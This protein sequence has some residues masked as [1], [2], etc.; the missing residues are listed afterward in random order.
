M[1]LWRR[2]PAGSGRWT[3]RAIPEAGLALA[4]D[5]A[6]GLRVDG[7]APRDATLVARLVPLR[8]RGASAAALVVAPCARGL[9]VEGF[10]PLGVALLEDRSELRVGA[11]RLYLSRAVAPSVE[12]FDGDVAGALCARCTRALRR[13]DECL[14][15]G[16]C[17]AWHHEGERAE[18]AEALLC[19]SYDAACAGCRCGWEALRWSPEALG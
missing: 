5:A 3:A 10:P 9:L 12:S 7:E 17:G 11:E 14:R 6:G 18:G 13:G 15:C 1:Q 4:L 19:A 2:E 8:R 16:S